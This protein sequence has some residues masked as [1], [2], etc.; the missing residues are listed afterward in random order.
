[1]RSFSDIW[2]LQLLPS[3]SSTKDTLPSPRRVARNGFS[4][5]WNLHVPHFFS[6][7]PSVFQLLFLVVPPPRLLLNLYLVHLCLLIFMFY[8]FP[9]GNHAIDSKQVKYHLCS[10]SFPSSSSTFSSQAPQS[11][12]PSPEVCNHFLPIL[13]LCILAWSY[14]VPPPPQTDLRESHLMLFSHP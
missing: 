8:F 14:P 9:A 6:C 2:T 1:M 13:L 3:S 5:G 10:C 7:F 4:L 11:L 12:G